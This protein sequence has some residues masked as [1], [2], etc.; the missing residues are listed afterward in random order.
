MNRYVRGQSVKCFERSNGLDPALYKTYLF[1]Y[2]IQGDHVQEPVP[3]QHMRPVPALGVLARMR[4]GRRDSR[5]T[6]TD[7]CRACARSRV[8]RLRRELPETISR[9]VHD[10]GWK[11]HVAATDARVAA[12]TDR[13]RVEPDVPLRYTVDGCDIL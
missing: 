8:R 2:R 3:R 13:L 9:R 12:P 11:A 5:P 10:A 7:R 1:L 6:R 4:D